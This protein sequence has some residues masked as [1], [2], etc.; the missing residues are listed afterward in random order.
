MKNLFTSCIIIITIISCDNNQNTLSGNKEDSGTV[1]TNGTI[2]PTRKE[3]N[4]K[5]VASFSKSVPNSLN[6]WHFSVGVYETKETFRYLM[7]M[8]YMELRETDTLKIPN[9][10]IEPKIE[11]HQGKDDN[12]CIVGFFDRSN[13][14]KEYKLVSAEDGKLK[15]TV[16]HHYGVATYQTE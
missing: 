5:P 15:I 2:S 8:E 7:K 12:S 10:G 11:I 4:S 13:N 16:L 6:N 9:I 3:I 14:F 1:V